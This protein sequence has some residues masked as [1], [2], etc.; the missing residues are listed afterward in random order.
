MKIIDLVCPNCNGSIQLDED[1]EFGFCMHCGHRIVLADANIGNNRLAQVKRL[2]EALDVKASGRNRNEIVSLCD[3]IIELDPKDPDAWYYKG[4]YVMED[5]ILSEALAYWIKS[6]QCMSYEQASQLREIMAD[7]IADTLF[8]EGEDEIPL[9]KL[10]SLS[11]TM[12]EKLEKED[13]EV[14]VDFFLDVINKILEK[15]SENTDS[16]D[17]TYPLTGAMIVIMAIS[18]RYGSI[19]DHRELFSQISD[20]FASIRDRM[21]RF[22]LS[23]PGLINENRDQIKRCISFLK[24]IVAEIDR[25][26]SSHTED[27]V[28]R[29]NDYWIQDGSLMLMDS[30]L[31]ARKADFDL[32]DAG[33]LSISKYRNQR[34][35]GL[36]NYVD[37][38]FEPLSRN[39]C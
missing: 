13:D 22:S 4:L 14:P 26:M 6:A 28:D 9:T 8:S 23:D 21:S 7:A 2:K 35:E 18:A 33:V 12:D 30:L 19:L 37:L 38:Y 34:K 36:R 27:E 11:A 32:S 10:L 15:I 17:I 25:A 1:K 29:L 39:L 3:R 31:S 24:M 5:G 16:P 20:E